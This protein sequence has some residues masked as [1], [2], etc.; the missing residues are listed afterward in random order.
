MRILLVEDD[1]LV[2]SGIRD[3]LTRIRYSV[4][5][6]RDGRHALSALQTGSFELV[7]LDLTLPGLDGLEVLRRVR[8]RGTTTPLLILSARDT[9]LHRVSGLDAG[10]DDYMVKPFDLDELIARVRA[11][12]RRARNAPDN[13]LRHGSL[14]LDPATLS[15]T[16]K[17]QPVSLQRREFMLL[18]KLLESAGQ[19]LNRA[20][21]EESIYGW[22]GDVESNTIEVHIHNLRRKLYPDIIRTIRGMGYTVDPP[23]PDSASA[24]NP[25]LA[26]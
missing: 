26:P 15:V 2:G 3:A 12:R 9:P 11:L 13:V 21:L 23:Q 8:A 16:Y 6:V 14:T 22:E 17:G 19:I 1:E 20:Q 24:A 10:A 7:I 4:E 18:H 5:W 25:H